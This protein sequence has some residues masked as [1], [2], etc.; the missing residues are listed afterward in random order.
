MNVV[1]FIQSF[2]SKKTC[3]RKRI[4]KVR[5]TREYF[6]LTPTQKDEFSR[7]LKKSTEEAKSDDITGKTGPVKLLL[8]LGRSLNSSEEDD[9]KKT[10]M[11]A[12]MKVLP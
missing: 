7:I 10:T 8:R 4:I 5:R 1:L 2:A 3:I 9:D 6:D 12:L 11:K